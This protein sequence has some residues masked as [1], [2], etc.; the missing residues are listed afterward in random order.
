MALADPQSLTIGG[1]TLSHPR[2][3][4]GDG[5]GV[6]TVEDGSSVLRVATTRGKRVRTLVRLENSKL[7]A[8]PLLPSANVPVSASVQLVI[9]RPIQGFTNAQVKDI[10]LGLTTWLTASTAANTVKIIGGES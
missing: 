4:S 7:S 2:T 3:G 10:V 9:D 8:D 6:F 5:T 1:S